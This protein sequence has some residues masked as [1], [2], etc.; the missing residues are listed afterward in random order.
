M[1]A[2]SV[3]VDTMLAD[4]VSKLDTLSKRMDALETGEGHHNPVKGDD[5]D[6]DRKDDATSVKRKI[7]ADDDDD[8]DDDRKDDDGELEIKHG[9][10]KKQDK[11][12]KKSDKRSDAKARKRDDDDDDDRRDDDDEEEEPKERKDRR[13]DSAKKS[14]DDDDD[15]DEE[16]PKERK[17]RRKDSAK[18]ADDDDDD[19]DD[20]DRRK[21]DDDDDD[22]D[23][24]RRKDSAKK[25]DSISDLRRQIS[26]QTSTIR[27]LEALMRPKSDDEHAAFAD[28]QAKADAVFNGFGQRAPRP[29]EGESLLDYRKRMATKL[30]SHSSVWKSVKLS[31]LPEE[32]FGIAEGQVYADAI[33]AASNP[34]DLGAGELRQVTKTD[35][36][37][38]IRTIVFYGN[39]S[40]VKSMGRPGRRVQSFRTM[41]SQ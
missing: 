10:E 8:D 26:R 40:F 39:E 30:K 24:D 1:A 36:T 20:D 6:D 7:L 14:D 34:T 11:K 25:A 5:D 33:S 13:K 38:G 32:A 37:T 28:A 27:R 23:D 3:S 15:D 12:S 2:G 17:D 35:P 4:A 22:D 21:A 41:A 19:D 31:Q 29:L 9:E 16:E 18:K